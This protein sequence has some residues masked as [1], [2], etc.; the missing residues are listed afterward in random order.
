MAS[1]RL[2]VTTTIL[3]FGAATVYFFFL[4]FVPLPFLTLTLEL[5][6]ILAWFITG[7]ALFIPL[8]VYA[9]QMARSEGNRG[10]RQILD[11]L[12]VRKFSRRD[13]FYAFTGLFLVLATTALIYVGSSWLSVYVGMRSLST[14]PWFLEMRELHGQE[15]WLL[16]VW[17]YM[18]FFNIV[19]EEL[20]WRGYLQRHLACKHPWVLCS[21]LWMGF[22]APFG[23]DLMIVLTP[24]IVIIPY[25]YHKTRNT[26][27]G[28]FI[29]ALFNG[30]VFV[31]VSLG[32]I[33]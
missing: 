17:V 1:S 21:V 18:F 5:D 30:P 24:V 31:A 20:L 16:L 26:L 12:D 19:G 15:R 6:S 13:S 27:V 14:A 9:I 4:L 10:I 23:L 7:F 22:H 29:H 2:T 11:A 32:F 8:F 28:V 25:F 3:T 33:K